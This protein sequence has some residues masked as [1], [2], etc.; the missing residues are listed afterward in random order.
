M[1]DGV[2]I[3]KKI[4]KS[5]RLVFDREED[6][7]SVKD[8]FSAGKIFKFAEGQVLLLWDLNQP[9]RPVI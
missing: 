4:E 6:L 1:R 7:N 2:S 3:W 5:F 8:G 9:N